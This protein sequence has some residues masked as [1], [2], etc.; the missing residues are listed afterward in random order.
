MDENTSAFSPLWLFTGFWFFIGCVLPWLLPASDNRYLF[1]TMLVT[2]SVCCYIFWLGP[3]L[4]Q[5]N[6]IVGPILRNT[7][8]F[9][10][11][12]QWGIESVAR[13]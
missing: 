13:S 5:M 7:S 10:V 1:Q 11:A 4:M 3:F 8:Y 12:E 2:T 6:P 9:I